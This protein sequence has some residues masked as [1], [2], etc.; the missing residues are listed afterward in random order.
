MINRNQKRFRGCPGRLR[1]VLGLLAAIG[2]MTWQLAAAGPA[3][4]AAGNLDP[5]FG[6]GGIVTTDF[7]RSTDRA[8]ALVIQADGKLV[9]AGST[10]RSYEPGAPSGFGLTRYM[11]NGNLDMTFGA[12]GKVTT[13]FSG[14]V[15]NALVVQA[16]GKLVAA[17][18]TSTVNGSGDFALARYN[19]DGTLDTTFGVGGTVTTDF[20][21]GHDDR[22]NALVVQADGKLV[23]AGSTYD[24]S[25][26]TT[27]GALARYNSD[28]TLDPTFG[29]GGQV[30]GGDVAI[31]A[32]VVQADGKLVTAGGSGDFVLVRYDSDGTLD[33][34]F[35][36]GGTVTTDFAGGYDGAY[37]LVVQADG[38]LVAAGVAAVPVVGSDFALARYNSDGTLDTGFGTG[39]KVTTD[40]AGKGDWAHALVVQNGMLVAAGTTTGPTTYN[41]SYTD[42]ALARYNPNGTLDA[43]FGTGGKV[44]T[45]ITGSS[46][47]AGDQANALAVQENG[48][49]VAAGDADRNRKLGLSDFGLVR[50]QAQDSQQ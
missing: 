12:G 39:G 7:Y 48:K 33:I 34:T 30:I 13:V 20:A 16:D 3:L 41:I 22:A 6:P 35:G 14:G 44:T 26:M 36:A 4:A 1:G 46:G 37:A 23:A 18:R 27:N 43:G 24:F 47:Y 17:G 40:F 49:L 2:L 11:P 8:N 45:D 29:T 32:L 15:I 5:S 31:A 9:A 21:G 38:K 42:F 19:P 25:S 28:G 50:Y 10:S